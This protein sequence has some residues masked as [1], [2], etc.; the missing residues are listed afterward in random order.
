MMTRVRL[1]ASTC[2]L[3]AMAGAGLLAASPAAAQPGAE[4]AQPSQLTE[5]IVTARKRQESILN[6]PVIETA[7][8]AV[9]LQRY[10]TQD[11]KDI[12]TLVPGIKLG[13]SILSIGTQISLR[14]VGTTTFNPGVDQS[15]SLNLDG[16]QL[17]QGLTYSSGFFDM[18]QVE[19]LKGPQALFYGKS[20]PGGVISIRTADPTDKVEVIARAGYEFEARERQLQL[21]VSGPVTD[22]V[23]VR[24]AGQYDAQDGFYK[25]DA[26]TGVRGGRA[27]DDNRLS[28]DEGYMLRATVLW[29]PTSQFDARLKLNHVRDKVTEAGAFQLAVCPDGVG[30]VTTFVG[31]IQ[32][33]D[34]NDKCKIDRHASMVDM[35]PEVYG[36]LPNGGTGYTESTQTFGTLE[37]NYR[38]RPDV[39]L[40]STTGY[41]LL[42]SSSLFNTTTSGF[43]GPLFAVTNGFH[44]REWTEELRAN[45]D[46]A[47]PLNFTAGGFLQRARFSDL[48]GL[49]GNTTLFFPA[50]LQKG[51]QTVDI[52]T[53]S[54]FGQLRYRV[55][56]E[57]EVAFGARYTDEKR[58][59]VGVDE[60]TGVK[61]PVPLI[62]PEVHSKTTSPEL[63]ITY[64][65]TDDFTVFGA[66]K[67]GYKSGSFDTATP[68]TATPSNAFGDE[69]VQGGEVGMKSRW[70]D[71]RLLFNAAWYNYRYTGLQVGAIIPVENGVPVTRTINAGSALVTGIETDVAYRPEW[72]EG[73]G[74]NASLNW[75]HAQFKS[76]EGV[77]CYGGQT[78]ADGCN[79]TFDP[80]VNGGRGG[81][82]TMSQSG[83]PLVRAP[84]WQANFG[85]DYETDIGHD[86]SVVLS[87]NN[88]FSSKYLT[89]LGLVHYQKSTFKTDLSLALQGPRDRWEFAIIGK[90]L[91]NELTSGN[92]SNS[93]AQ[94]GLF[95][96]SEITGAVTSP[97]R[98]PAGTDELG[99]WMDRGREFWLR[100]TVRPFN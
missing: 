57:V 28:P 69:K 29:N 10:Q 58:T 17:T 8:P 65:P 94:G 42:H 34:P 64:R 91:T 99:C 70:L 82:T 16:L 45:S 83:L 14:G 3:L 4:A 7:L 75:N 44:R 18:S 46:F 21:I 30:P 25:N 60:T 89:G 63:T 41:Y 100:L 68:P 51:T 27:P 98:G 80:N 73:L 24:L 92:C 19:V 76:L 50:L 54:V 61:I 12:A 47:G 71:R 49:Q 66:L 74:L 1:L 85:F 9:Q 52:K 95:P 15:V 87:N 90:N 36:G 78:V 26:T 62:T 43:S 6:V 39:A 56:P 33:L 93:N 84:K 20:S 22:T 86:M 96:G 5:I 55:I 40:T 35:V 38:L 59:D 77:P 23:K 53:N 79:A 81:F 11:L 37:L 13:D 67:R 31:P 72:F 88:Q 48:V 32:F 2:S 97:I